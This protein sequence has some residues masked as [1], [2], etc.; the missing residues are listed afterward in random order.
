MPTVIS[1]YNRSLSFIKITGVSYT[2]VHSTFLGS[3]GLE[4]TDFVAMGLF[5]VSVCLVTARYI[6]TLASMS[7]SFN[8]FSRANTEIGLIDKEEIDKVASSTLLQE[9]K[10]IMMATPIAVCAG[11][12]MGAFLHDASIEI[13]FVVA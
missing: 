6:W 8:S 1:I 9:L 7:E 5:V 11:G 3:N 4:T 2:Y 13:H 10:L 12:I